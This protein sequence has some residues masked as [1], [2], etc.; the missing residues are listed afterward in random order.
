MNCSHALHYVVEAA[1]LVRATPARNPRLWRSTAIQLSDKFADC[2]DAVRRGHEVAANADRLRRY[3]DRLKA[4]GH[5]R[6]RGPS[7]LER[8]RAAVMKARL[9]LTH[10]VEVLEDYDLTRCMGAETIVLGKRCPA[11]GR[12]TVDTLAWEIVAQHTVRATCEGIDARAE[13]E[14]RERV[15]LDRM[16]SHAK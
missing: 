2:M 9:W 10:G 7:R 15:A 11:S 1:R 3:R 12:L 16:T 13:A 8:Y 5:E 4:A 6:A 14:R